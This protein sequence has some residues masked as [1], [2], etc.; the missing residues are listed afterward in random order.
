MSDVSCGAVVKFSRRHNYV[1][2]RFSYKVLDVVHH[3][4]FLEN[5][6]GDGAQALSPWNYS[7]F[8]VRYVHKF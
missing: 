7:D 2:S 3:K 6:G 8:N 5:Y 1:R 4:R